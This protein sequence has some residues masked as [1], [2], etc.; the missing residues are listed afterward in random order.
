MQ[1]SARQ[2]TR[3]ARQWKQWPRT[4]WLRDYWLLEVWVRGHPANNCSSLD[5]NVDTGLCNENEHVL[6]QLHYKVLYRLFPSK[7]LVYLHYQLSSASTK[8]S[9]LV[10][11]ISSPS[12]RSTSCRFLG[13]SGSSRRSKSGSSETGL[14]YLQWSHLTLIHFHCFSSLR[15]VT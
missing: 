5:G 3:V 6:L 7:L 1:S 10:V 9:L 14:A 15:T 11:S 8:I 12:R 2:V 4:A 13:S